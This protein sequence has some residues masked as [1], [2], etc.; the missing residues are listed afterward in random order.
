MANLTAE[1]L[2]NANG[3]A[4]EQKIHD[5]KQ[6][7]QSA[8]NKLKQISYGRNEK[9]EIRNHNYVEDN[10]T[11]GLLLGMAMGMVAGSLMTLTLRRGRR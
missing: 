2:S 8:E 10:P 7:I 6:D 11:K 4:H 5:P 1:I 9:R 3:I